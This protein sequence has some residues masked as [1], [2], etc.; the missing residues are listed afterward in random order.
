MHFKNKGDVELGHK[1]SYDHG[2]LVSSGSV[3]YEV[4]DDY[5]GNTIASKE[6]KSPNL[7]FVDKE[8]YHRITALE[9]NTVCACIHAL[10]TNDEELIDP[11]FL[12]EPLIGDNKGIIPKTINEKTGKEWIPFTE[13]KLSE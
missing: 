12:I 2:T 8:K 1:H 3:L 11:D 4:L 10:R 6:F 9:D 5:N 7:I 13:Q